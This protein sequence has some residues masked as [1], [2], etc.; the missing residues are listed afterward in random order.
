MVMFEYLNVISFFLVFIIVDS[1]NAAVVII[2]GVL[3][4]LVSGD[5]GW[6]G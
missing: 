1:C 4:G 3:L 2:T 6:F 5:L